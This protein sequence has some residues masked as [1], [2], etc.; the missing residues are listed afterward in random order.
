MPIAKVSPVIRVAIGTLLALFVVWLATASAYWTGTF[1]WQW[2]WTE[3]GLFGG[4]AIGVLA[5]ATWPFKTI[6]AR[7]MGMLVFAIVL[8]PA[9]F[10]TGLLTAC[11]FG[12]C[13]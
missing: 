11:S 3:I 4:L 8:F 12:D 1:S 13:L 2:R 6:A 5:F 7:L 10:L 9:L